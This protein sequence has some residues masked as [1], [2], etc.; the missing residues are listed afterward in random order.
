M[1]A[2]SIEI[3]EGFGAYVVKLKDGQ[4]MIGMLERQDAS[5]IALKDLA[6]QRHTARTNDIESM[7]ASPISLMPEGLLAGLNDAELRDLFA[8]LMKP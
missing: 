3:R 8:F 2:P 4:V 1:L 7:D 5:G 6:A